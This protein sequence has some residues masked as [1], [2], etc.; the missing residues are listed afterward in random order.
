VS[1]ELLIRHCAPTLASIKTGSLFNCRYESQ[2][3]MLESIRSMNRRLCKKG[4][5]FLPLQ[6]REG[7]GLIYAY[8]PSK[9]CQDLSH[10]AAHR[11]LDSCGY[12]CQNPNRCLVHLKKR[13]AAQAAFPHEIG[14]FLG[15]PPEDVEGFMQQKKAKCT[16]YWKVYGDVAAAQR[17]FERYKKCTRLYLEQWKKGNALEKLTVAL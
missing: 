13:L 6:Y 15:Y 11:L 4:L 9:L 1:E 2:E 14:L 5:R 17:T 8:R 10:E 3:A 16:G 7:L 12:C